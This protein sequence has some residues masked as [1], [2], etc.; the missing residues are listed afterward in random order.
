MKSIT[1][2]TGKRAGRKP[3]TFEQWLKSCPRTDQKLIP[4]TVTVSLSRLDW[5]EF[6]T[7]AAANGRTLDEELVRRI[8]WDSLDGAASQDQDDTQ[9]DRG[10]LRTRRE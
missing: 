7:V 9:A 1:L 8:D 5:I 2:K 3:L 6:A 4:I 10:S